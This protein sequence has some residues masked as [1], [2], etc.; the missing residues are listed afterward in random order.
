MVL[1]KPLPL[2]LLYALPLTP[3]FV[4]FVLISLNNV[5]HSRRCLAL[6]STQM[7]ANQ[8]SDLQ[9]G[10]P[11]VGPALQLSRPRPEACDRQALRPCSRR[12]KST[13]IRIEGGRTTAHLWS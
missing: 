6:F 11:S 7:R 1:L 3:P 8:H 4:P 12:S 13:S 9:Q 5:P 10:Q 2:L